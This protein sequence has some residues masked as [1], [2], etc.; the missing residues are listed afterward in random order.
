M[1]PDASEGSESGQK[2]RCLQDP[3]VLN[4]LI[5]LVHPPPEDLT[6]QRR[7]SRNSSPVH[8]AADLESA[9]PSIKKY[10][11][12]AANEAAGEYSPALEKVQGIQNLAATSCPASTSIGVHAESPPC[13]IC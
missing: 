10:E 1:E 9:V 12:N 11:I 2:Q 8:S 4:R 7:R 13:I 3:T 5:T 6:K